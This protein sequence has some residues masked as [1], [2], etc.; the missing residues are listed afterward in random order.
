MQNDFAKDDVKKGQIFYDH[1]KHTIMA[2]RVVSENYLGLLSN[3]RKLLLIS[4][5]NL[6]RLRNEEV[7][8]LGWRNMA[9][10]VFYFLIY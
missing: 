5:H 4:R 1:I 8:S 6:M 7:D 3:C 9:P 10:E 2:S